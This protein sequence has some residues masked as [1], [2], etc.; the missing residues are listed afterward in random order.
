[1]FDLIP[2][3]PSWPAYVSHAEAAA[4]AR[5]R[6]LR[7]PTEAEFMRA[8]YGAP[9]GGR[10]RYPWGAAEPT[11]AH[12]VFDFS[13]WD[14]EPAAAIPPAGVRGGSTI[15]SAMAGSGRAPCSRR[16]TDLWPC[17]RIPSTQPISLTGSTS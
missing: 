15:S 1:M 13:S 11:V 14:P 17:R 4:Y 3:P 10:R 12:G 6:R 9:E 8:A 5:W 16:S 7:L 2:L